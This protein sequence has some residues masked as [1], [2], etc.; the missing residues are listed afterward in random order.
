MG[1]KGFECNW[2]TCPLKSAT[3]IDLKIILLY[4][5][6]FA[7]DDWLWVGSFWFLESVLWFSN[8]PV[9]EWAEEHDLRILNSRQITWEI[10]SP[11]SWI[12]SF[13]KSRKDIIQRRHWLCKLFLKF[14]FSKSSNWVLDYGVTSSCRLYGFCLTQKRIKMK[15]RLVRSGE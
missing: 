2:W 10:E 14:L 6:V 1:L 7:L 13:K 12:Y 11:Y 15:S 5:L 8:F 4:V 3:I 9:S